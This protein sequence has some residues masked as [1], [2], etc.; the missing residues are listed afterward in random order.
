MNIV[1]LKEQGNLKYCSGKYLESIKIYNTILD[2]I[3]IESNLKLKLQVLSNR[4]ASFI[5][6]ARYEDSIKDCNAVLERDHSNIKVL[7]RRATCFKELGKDLAV[8]MND[9]KKILSIDPKNILAKEMLKDLIED[10]NKQ[11]EKNIMNESPNIILL[12]LKTLLCNIDLNN[13]E[14]ILKNKNIIETDIFDMLLKIQMYIID[15][16]TEIIMNNDNRDNLMFILERLIYIHNGEDFLQKSGNVDHL[17]IG[18]NESNLVKEI[19]KYVILSWNLLSLLIQEPI[20]NLNELCDTN[21]SNI[22]GS[23]NK[24]KTLD[25]NELREIINNRNIINI[26]KLSI[27]MDYIER[28]KDNM[29]EVQISLLYEHIFNAIRF[30]GDLNN[31][32]LLHF[33]LEILKKTKTNFKIINLSLNCLTSWFQK[34]A[35]MGLKVEALELTYNIEYLIKMMMKSIYGTYEHSLLVGYF[36]SEYEDII[37]KC[38]Y[39]LSMIIALLSD[40][41]RNKEIDILKLTRQ[42]IIQDYLLPSIVDPNILNNTN[43]NQGTEEIVTSSNWIIKNP[44]GFTTGLV[45]LKVSHNSNRDILQ[46]HILVYPQIMHCLLLITMVNC[47]EFESIIRR[48]TLNIKDI[49]D[50]FPSIFKEDIYKTLLQYNCIEVLSY[51]MEY[52]QTRIS[53]TKEDDTIIMLY[54]ICKQTLGDVVKSEHSSVLKSLDSTCRLLCGLVKTTMESNKVLNILL[55]EIFISEL[56]ITIWITLKQEFHKIISKEDQKTFFSCLQNLIEALN[57]LAIHK[58]FKVTLLDIKINESNK[59]EKNEA[60]KQN[61]LE[62]TKSNKVLFI[63]EILNIPQI[64]EFKQFTNKGQSNLPQILIYL[65]V[66]FIENVLISNETDPSANTSQNI[67]DNKDSELNKEE[68]SNNGTNFLKCLRFY[69]QKDQNL[70]FDETQLSQLEFLYRK[71]PEQMKSDR[72]GFYDRGDESL[73][74]SFRQLLV[75]STSTVSTLSNILK[76]LSSQTTYTIIMKIGNSICDLISPPESLNKNLDSQSLNDCIANRGRIIQ[77]GGLQCLLDCISFIEQHHK[78]KSSNSIS[79]TILLS[80]KYILDRLREYR[81]G[82]SRLLIATPPKLITYKTLMTCSIQIQALLED[83]HELLQYEAA[84]SLTNILSINYNQNK[85]TESQIALRIYDNS[86]GWNL[87]KDLC[88]SNNKLLVSA[89]LEGLCNFCNKDEVVYRHFIQSKHK[90]LEDLKLFIAFIFEDNYRIQIACLGALAM[91]SAYIDVCTTMVLNWDIF[92]TKMISFVQSLVD[93]EANPE[94]NER[95]LFYFNNILHLLSHI[96]DKNENKTNNA[97]IKQLR[98]KLGDH[99]LDLIKV[100]LLNNIS[101][102]Q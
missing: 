57:I 83:D 80:S 8:A 72:N 46:N 71:L 35:S 51:T 12:N 88:F 76:M 22:I 75:F 78:N 79:G 49:Y 2:S 33:I 82:I 20:P 77:Q 36:N 90:G 48:S 100:K 3:E 91:L 39:I 74:N 28:L 84:L 54:T 63:Y 1:K 70:D 53:L 95:I 102:I 24:L 5:K 14:E 30:L 101:I 85:D 9:L 15:N 81:Q 42:Y 37:L 92:G 62:D 65:Y 93:K 25:I 6:L 58:D 52:K 64:F 38:G 67:K 68:F 40:K 99:E 17:S 31:N 10:Q 32:E 29:Y 41:N 21:K 60:F 23:Y 96:D 89:G 43:N 47:K 97:N 19:P 56:I 26:S 94:L 69:G 73:V 13:D 4:A 16:G 7:Y 66:S 55:N 18:E 44:I 61:S 11:N 86:K 27:F 59:S 87:F 98:N 50:D 34:R 45:G